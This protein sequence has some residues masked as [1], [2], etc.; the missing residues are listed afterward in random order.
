METREKFLTVTI[1]SID[2]FE[3]DGFRNIWFHRR[4]LLYQL[5]KNFFYLFAKKKQYEL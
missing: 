1:L 4:K 5:Q 2:S 3:V